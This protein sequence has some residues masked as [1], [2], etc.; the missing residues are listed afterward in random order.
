MRSAGFARIDPTSTRKFWPATSRLTPRRSNT[1][2]DVTEWPHGLGYSWEAIDAIFASRKS[3]TAQERAHA[4]QPSQKQGRPKKEGVKGDVVTLKTGRGNDP[5]Y[6]TARIARD[7]PDIL[8]DMKAGKY[9]STRQ[10]A[11]AGDKSLQHAAM[12]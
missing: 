2:L 1:Q 3:I 6:L 11:I 12:V 8:E 4:A 7:R 9:S 10:A 5:A